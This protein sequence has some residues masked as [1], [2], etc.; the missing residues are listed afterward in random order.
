M[1]EGRKDRA[2]DVLVGLVLSLTAAVVGVWGIARRDRP[3]HGMRDDGMLGLPTLQRWDASYRPPRFQRLRS[4]IP[5]FE[6][7]RLA[8]LGVIALIIAVA[9]VVVYSHTLGQHG[10][11]AAAFE[12]ALQSVEARHAQAKGVSDV[13]TAYAMLVDARTRLE[14]LQS[15]VS[16]DAQRASVASEGSAISADIDALSGAQRFQSVQV[17]GSVP[18]SPT[19]VTPRLVAGGGRVFLLSDAFY[20]VDNSGTSLVRLLKSGDK[21]GDVTV[22]TLRGAAW[23]DDR[24]IVVDAQRAYA[25]DPATGT[26]QAEPLGVF[27]QDGF[28]DTRAVDVYAR[29]LYTLTP[30]TGQILKFSA[31]SY[32]DPPE[33]WTGGTSQ[34][35]LQGAVDLAVDGRVFA[36]LGD[37]RVLDFFR[38]RLEL[39]LEPTLVP[40]LD[41]PVALVAMPD[42]QYLYMLNSSDGRIVRMSRDGGAVQQFLPSPDA[43]KISDAQDFV[44]DESSGVAYVLAHDVVYTVRVP[45]PS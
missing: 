15:S 3:S 24:P 35:D 34:A 21:L 11:N 39:T 41:S 38:S 30:A 13:P 40:A 18:K 10:D 4:A 25:L 8:L 27:D 28:T 20:Q 2:V 12:Q 1:L 26:W 19:G 22:G 36:L 17:L 31:D 37:G 23:R 7:S 43:P 5:R 44:L 42:S 14:E 45:P 33:D 6:A 32:S 16:N 9:S 29:N